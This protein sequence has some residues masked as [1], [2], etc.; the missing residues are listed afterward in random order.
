MRTISVFQRERGRP[1]KFTRV[2]RSSLLAFHPGMAAIHAGERPHR[3][4]LD[5]LVSPAKVMSV[6]K[7][8]RCARYRWYL[9]QFPETNT[10]PDDAALFR[11]F[12]GSMAHAGIDSASDD[13]GL[14]F[15]MWHSLSPQWVVAGTADLVKIEA[16]RATIFDFKTTRTIPKEPYASAIMQVRLYAWLLRQ[17][18]CQLPIDG[19]IAYLS[20]AG[21]GFRGYRFELE[22]YTTDEV[23]ELV[24][25]AEREEPPDAEPVSSWECG[26]CPFSQCPRHGVRPEPARPVQDDAD[27][28]PFGLQAPEMA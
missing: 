23:R 3:N 16:D 6:T 13:P 5:G 19:L 12:M 24:A 7:L 9:N 18:G 1:V 14:E 15:S 17:H 21:D 25:V 20:R 10:E 11:M 4:W 27:P 28:D 2:D 8:T 26:R 22:P